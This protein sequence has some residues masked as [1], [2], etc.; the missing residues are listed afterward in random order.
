MQFICENLQKRLN[1]HILCPVRASSIFLLRKLRN[2]K[3]KKIFFFLA[4]SLL[5]QM[6]KMKLNSPTFSRTPCRSQKIS[7]RCARCIEYVEYDIRLSHCY[8]LWL[9]I[10]CVCECVFLCLDLIVVYT[11]L[12]HRN[13]VMRLSRFLL[14]RNCDRATDQ[15]KMILHTFNGLLLMNKWN[16]AKYLLHVRVR[17]SCVFVWVRPWSVWRRRIEQ[18]IFFLLLWI[19]KIVKN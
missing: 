19:K 10:S 6:M 13:L 2:E 18:I 14:R 5:D 9:V 17:R 8:G 7:M 3:K 16:C 12:F 11:T 4:L 1:R 15:K